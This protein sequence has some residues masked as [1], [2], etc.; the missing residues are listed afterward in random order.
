NVYLQGAIMGMQG[1]EIAARFDEI[2]AFAGVERFVDTPVKRYSSGMNARLG[3][4]IA[5]HL[6]PDV[7]LI[8]EVLAVGDLAFQEKCHERMQQFRRDGVAMVFVSHHLPAVAQ[9]CNRVVLLDRGRVARTGPPAEVI[10]EYC[11][12]TRATSA[13]DEVSVSATL[14][15]RGQFGAA[16]AFAVEPGAR[17]QLDVA[18]AFHIDVERAKLGIV[19]WDLTRELYVYG[20]SSEFVGIPPIGARAGETRR[21]SFAPRAPR[22][23]ALCDR[24]ESRRP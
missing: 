20:A 4:S 13:G 21:F 22:A 6:R 9:L 5:A 17:L 3:F 10:A 7:L 1:A 19:V 24:G 16:D 14:R 12:G 11:G 18:L 23:R 8:D 15:A 2:V